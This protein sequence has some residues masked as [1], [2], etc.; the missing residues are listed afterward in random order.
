MVF[1]QCI[2]HQQDSM[3]GK[4]EHLGLQNIQMNV[5]VNSTGYIQKHYSFHHTCTKRKSE[6]KTREALEINKLKTNNEND[7]TSQF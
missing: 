3:S 4:W 2:E 7:K 5:M 1:T 6:K